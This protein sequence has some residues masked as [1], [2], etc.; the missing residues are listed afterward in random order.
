MA[1]LRKLS[2]DGPR[3]GLV[4]LA[5][6]LIATLSAVSLSTRSPRAAAAAGGTGISN[7]VEAA[8]IWAELRNLPVQSKCM[9][10]EG[11]SAD[12][13]SRVLL[14]R[15][16]GRADQEWYINFDGGYHPV[17]NGVSGKCLGAAGGSADQG[18]GLVVWDCEINAPNQQWR[19]EWSSECGGIILVNQRPGHPSEKGYLA[20][21]EGGSTSDG[22]RIIQWPHAFSR[23][24]T[25]CPF[26]A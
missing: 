7:K 19:V 22:A 2:P 9:G 21:V 24:Q 23:D 18:A 6:L 26:Y 13:G 1:I 16:N 12:N 25:W 4:A 17:Y 11:G 5:G 14:W 20:S 3:R 10:V 8:Y 15:C